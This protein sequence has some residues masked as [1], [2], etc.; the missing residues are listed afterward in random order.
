M[1]DN[2]VKKYAP[3]LALELHRAGLDIYSISKETGLTLAEI[4]QLLGLNEDTPAQE[5]A[6]TAHPVTKNNEAI[7][8]LLGK[9]LSTSQW[10]SDDRQRLSKYSEIE[11]KCL[12]LMSR[13]VDQY[14]AIPEGDLKVDS[15]KAKLA[16]DFLRATS[17][18]RRELL[19]RF[20]PAKTAEKDEE[21]AIDVEF[22]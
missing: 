1:K 6:S 9:G 15:F 18:V 20:A 19:D 17:D 13:L 12:N 22:V 14:S 11:D 2:F 8:E 10:L 3:R 16:N 7:L 5:Y 21:K 4:E